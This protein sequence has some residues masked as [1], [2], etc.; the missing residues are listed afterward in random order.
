MPR[1]THAYPPKPKA[2]KK[3]APDAKPAVIVEAKSP[4]QIAKNKR[5]HRL[6]E[7]GY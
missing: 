1:I 3:A 7:R 5:I 4:K 2:P 6:R